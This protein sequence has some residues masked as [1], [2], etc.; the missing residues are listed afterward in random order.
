MTVV[1]SLQYLQFTR[2]D[3]AFIVNKLFQFTSCPMITHWTVVKYVLHYLAGTSDR[4]LFLQKDSPLLL[5]AFF[6]SDWVGDRNDRSSTIS[7]VVLLASHPVS[8]SSKKQQVVSR[9]STEAKYRVIDSTT[10]ELCWVHN[11][12]KE[13]SITPAQP[14]VI[15]CDNLGATYVCANPVFH[16]RMKHLELDFHFIHK[17]VRQGLLRVSHVSSKDQLDDMLTKSLPKSSFELLRS[18]IGIANRPTILRGHIRD[19]S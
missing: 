18:K 12:L 14:L 2:L 13:L 10:D 19:I 4:S 5:H 3:I 15:Y 9:S 6:D 11:L 8:Q 16:S 7:Y 1:G 17:L